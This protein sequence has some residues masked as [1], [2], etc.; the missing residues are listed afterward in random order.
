MHI[1]PGVL[2]CLAS[3]D[4]MAR[5]IAKSKLEALATTVQ[6]SLANP[7]TL[8]EL[9]NNFKKKLKAGY[10]NI[11]RRETRPEHCYNQQQPQ[12]N[13]AKLFYQIKTN[14]IYYKDPNP[15]GRLCIPGDKELFKQ[16]FS[17]VHDEMGHVRYAQAHQQ[18]SQ[19]LY[20]CHMAK[21]LRKYLHHCPKCQ[22][23]ITPHHSPYKLLQP[24]ILRPRLLYTI[25]IDFILALPTASEGFDSAMLVTNKY[26]KQVTF[27]AGKIAWRAK[28]WAIM[29]LDQLN[30]VNWEL[31]SAIFLDHNRQFVTE[32]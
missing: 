7:A 15:G 22:L 3:C 21:L 2:S 11:S 24:F 20:I 13:A 28:E 32:L 8:V 25:A 31:L 16:L 1:I 23:Q 17:Q 27:I 12:A 30:Q 5:S 14:L 26:S 4:K 6:K 9:S 29:L 18:L 19:G 10:N